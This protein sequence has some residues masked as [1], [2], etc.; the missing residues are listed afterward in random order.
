MYNFAPDER[1]RTLAENRN[2]TNVIA[3]A[4]DELIAK[5]AIYHFTCYR[6]YTRSA[7]TK[8]S[9]ESKAVESNGVSEVLKSL[10]DLYE[11][12]NAIHLEQLQ[13]KMT[14]VSGKKNLRRHRESKTGDFKFINHGNNLLCIQH[15]LKLMML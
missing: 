15:R 13:H 14:S 7:T 9:A 5:E 3:A 11:K 2:D 4:S 10:V 12:P 8:T 6:D 1:I